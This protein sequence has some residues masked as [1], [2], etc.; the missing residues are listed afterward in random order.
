M[1]SLIQHLSLN[2]LFGASHFSPFHAD[3]AHEAFVARFRPRLIE[4]LGKTQSQ[5]GRAAVLL[6]LAY[7]DRVEE[8]GRGVVAD[9]YSVEP[10]KGVMFSG[11]DLFVT[12]SGTAPGTM[13]DAVLCVPVV[14][15]RRR[16]FPQRCQRKH[17]CLGLDSRGCTT[18][19]P[20]ANA[21]VESPMP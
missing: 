7:L 10:I 11:N 6:A 4:S 8:T 16:E 1:A 19:E 20:H 14:R 3:S 12:L 18:P 15:A 21:A 5:A 2:L 17:I 13:D 9:I